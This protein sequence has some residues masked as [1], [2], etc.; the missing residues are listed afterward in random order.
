LAPG[1]I[2]QPISITLYAPN[3]EHYTFQT[4]VKALTNSAPGGYA[5]EH[6]LGQTLVNE[7]GTTDTVM[8]SLNSQPAT[9]VVVAVAVSDE[10]EV[11]VSPLLLTFTPLDWETPQP[12]EVQGVDD[13]DVDGDQRA[14]L[15]FAI[16]PVASDA[17]FHGAADQILAV[18]TEDNETAVASVIEHGELGYVLV[19]NSPRVERYDITN[20]AWLAPIPLPGAP[21]PA[22]VL[23]VDDD[24]MYIAYGKGVYRYDL[25]G[26]GRTHLLTLE[27]DVEG[28]HS[29]GDL[30]II[31]YSQGNYARLASLSKT[32]NTVIDT[33]YKYLHRISGSSIAPELNRII[34]RSPGLVYVDYNDDG[35]FNG[36]GANRDSGDHPRASRTWIFPNGAKVV[37]DGGTI[38]STDGLE[39]LNSFGGSLD[40]IDFLGGD[41]PI[42]LSGNTLTAYTQGIQPT[43]SYTL[44]YT[45]S[46]IFVNPT[47]VITFTEDIHSTTGVE[48]GL[49]ALTELNPA[50]PGLA[51]DPVGLPYTPDS[52]E[53]APDGTMLLYSKSHQSIFR[54]DTTTQSYGPT[55]PLIGTAKYMAYSSDTNTAYL[56]YESGLVRQIDL[57]V[58]DPVEEPFVE[59]PGFPVGLSTAGPYVFAV[60]YL[61]FKYMHYTFAPDGTLIESVQRYR[62]SGEYVWS[63]VNQKMYYL[64]G[65]SPTDLM[66]EEI[67]ADG[68]S[69]EGEAPGGIGGYKDSPLHTNYGFTY[70]IHV[71]PDGGV[72]LLGSG[73]IHD[74]LTLERSTL[75]LA[76][77]ITDAAWLGDELFTIRSLSG[78]SEIQ[79]WDT[80]TYGLLR[81][82]QLPG[83]AHALMLLSGDRMLAV[84]LDAGGIPVFTVM[85]GN[86]ETV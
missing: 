48:V 58:P 35:T 23:H 70:P 55:I 60:E 74:A 20:E 9:D 32:T 71:S 2:S 7:S 44:T 40:D 67:N 24:G 38:Y 47:H 59:L 13:V 39:Y 4:I 1:E 69:Y 77:S 18:V 33:Y 75:A 52:M 63:D 21:G 19:A 16:D 54:W 42:V 6:T 29:D 79:V 43:G 73:I 30:L 5:V 66:W 36:E 78:I 22:T 56:V 49:V 65:T 34:G 45:P 14:Y 17:A 53:L 84:T 80:T 8:V 57:S 26:G 76:N 31:N 61:D 72:A 27:Y 46:E 12:V 28:I 3:R 86:L 68:T 25:D 11:S 81:S 64:R 50:P 15:R 41:V 51:V 62:A 37:D 85:N 83:V 82:I 10:S